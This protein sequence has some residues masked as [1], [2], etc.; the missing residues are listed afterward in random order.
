MKQAWHLTR[1]WLVK[2]SSVTCRESPRFQSETDWAGL[3]HMDRG[4][5]LEKGLSSTKNRKIVCERITKDYLSWSINFLKCQ[6]CPMMWRRDLIS[7]PEV[8]DKPYTASIAFRISQLIRRIPVP[9]SGAVL[10]AVG[11]IGQIHII[12]L[13]KPFT[14]SL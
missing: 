13:C 7:S 11:D 9:T 14:H 10:K 3:G 1:L 6:N 8:H 5:A 4:L 12:I 2:C